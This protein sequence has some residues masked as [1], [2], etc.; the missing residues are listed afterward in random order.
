MKFRASE[1]SMFDEATDLGP[2]M[3]MLRAKHQA[4]C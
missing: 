3:K 2:R 1:T 4:L